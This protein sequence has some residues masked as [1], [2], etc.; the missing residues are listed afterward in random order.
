MKRNTGLLLVALLAAL[1]LLVSGCGEKQ[2]TPD[3]APDEPLMQEEDLTIEPQ[4]DA[5]FTLELPDGFLSLGADYEPNGKTEK[6]KCTDSSKRQGVYFFRSVSYCNSNLCSTYL[7]L[8]S[9]HQRSSSDRSKRRTHPS[10]QRSA[11]HRR[12][13]LWQEDRCDR[14]RCWNGTV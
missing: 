11:V 12:D 9:I 5:N 10:R 2:E 4:P 6:H 13:H 14:W 1:T 3:G 7:H 8:Y